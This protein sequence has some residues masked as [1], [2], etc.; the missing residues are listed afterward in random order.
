MRR[1]RSKSSASDAGNDAGAICATTGATNALVVL[2]KELKMRS[3]AHADPRRNTDDLHELRRE[4]FDSPPGLIPPTFPATLVSFYCG[5]QGELSEVWRQPIVGWVKSTGIAIA[6]P[7]TFEDCSDVYAI[8]LATG[9]NGAREWC[10]PDDERFADF[11]AACAHAC[12]RI[13]ERRERIARQCANVST[14]RRHPTAADG[15]HAA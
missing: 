1:D 14:A 3:F 6:T 12:R 10:F 5:Q 9:P 2:P 7:I 8:E 15:P 11:D 4:A 13:M